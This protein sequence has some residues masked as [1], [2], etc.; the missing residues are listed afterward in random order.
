MKK[1]YLL[2]LLLS[3]LG[4]TTF[5]QAPG[6]PDV[7]AGAVPA[8]CQPPQPGEECRTLTADYFETGATTSYSV[9]SVPY[10]PPYPFIGGTQ[11]SVN[12]DDIWS[13]A[14]NLPFSFCFY[15]NNYTSAFIGSNGVITFN[16]QTAGGF[17][18]YAFSQA[19]P[20]TSFPIRNAIYGVYQ[21]I[22]PSVDNNFANPNINYQVLGAYPCRTLVVNFSEV[23]Q[24]GT[25]CANNA[26]IGAQTSQIVLYETTNVIEVYVERRVPCTSW[27]NGVGLI[28]IQNA[29]GTQATVPPG[30][31]TGSW[32][33]IQEAW[34]FTPTGPSIVDFAWMDGPTQISTSTSVSVCPEE[35][36]TYTAVATYNRCD[37]TTVVKTANV[38]VEVADPLDLGEPEDF[39]I[40]ESGPG[41]FTFDLTENSE[42]ILNGLDPFINVITFHNSELDATE[43][44][45]PI[46]DADAANYVT[47]GEL[48]TIWVRVEN[49]FTS[50]IATT[51]FTIEASTAPQAGTP[52][53]IQVCDPEN[54]GVET[55][56]LT[57]LD[58]DVL[59]GQDPNQFV[60]TYHTSQAD[61]ENNVNA[62]TT[63]EAYTTGSATIYVRLTNA[64]D[65]DCYSTTS[66]IITVTPTPVVDEPEDVFACDDT[67]YVLPELTVGG[68]F[69]QPNGVG[70]IAEG[71]TVLATQTIYIYAESGTTPNNCTD[72][73]S[74]V[75]TVYEKPEVDTPADV[76]ACESYVLP[77]LTV[78]NYYTGPG[79][80]GTQLNAGDEITVTQDIYIYANSGIEVEC[81][82]E[83]VFNVEVFYPPVLVPATTI[84]VCDDNFD[85]FGIF[86]LLP[87]GQ[88]VINGQSGLT[89]TFHETIEGA[90]FG[91]NAINNPGSYSAIT[92]EIYIRVVQEGSTINCPSI[93]PLQLIVNPRPAIPT[94]SNYPLCDDNNPGDLEEEF[95]LTT[96]DAS[97]T[98]GVAGVPAAY[99][100]TQAYAL[101]G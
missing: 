57:A 77:A 88:E 66:F 26:N 56:D 64:A 46:S 61:A 24:F 3:L 91:S 13:S 50:C 22:D 90:E 10:A 89:V 18:N 30:R 7:T 17:C 6:C 23:A 15:G 97:V 93:E 54:D 86:N 31:N 75:V 47:D 70:P 36:T 2:L 98:G 63:P 45:S 20:N 87:A 33:A 58:G 21:D 81:S 43:G 76:D 100:L 44:F 4:L 8:I 32:T 79:G 101:S 1:N 83:H 40:C 59:Q 38:T 74:F 73:S 84:E 19:I 82:D 60:V 41:P 68:Y 71:T 39:Y 27:Q 65:E 55:F 34:R 72:E 42:T 48:E 37:G 28:G 52:A 9:S 53:N 69:N 85:D 5:A 29:A 11:I 62:I 94:P 49:Y 14:V 99:Y 51:S 12:T 92:G 25:N 96:R 95:D 78:G 16:T 67:G 80:T 35:T